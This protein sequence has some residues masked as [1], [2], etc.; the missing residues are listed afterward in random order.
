MISRRDALAGL[1]AL[2]AANWALLARAQQPAR[3]A[4]IGSGTPAGSVEALTAFRESMK[5]NAL[6]EGKDYVLDLFWSG[7]DYTRFPTLVQ[8]AL[9]RKPSIILVATIASVRAAQLATKTIPILM[10]GTNDPVGSGLVASLARPGGNTTGLA[11]MGNDR[12]PKLAQFV[13]EFL[14]KA[15]Y[16]A[17]LVNPLNPSNGPIFES[18]R[19]A[20]TSLGMS[21]V[22][23]EANSPE[24]IDDAFKALSTKRP[25]A[26]V[27][28]FDFIFSDQRGRI[29]QLGLKNK[30]PIFAGS[31]ASADA[32]ALI[33]FGPPANEL[34][35]RAAMYVKRILAGAKPADLPI[36]QPTKVELVLN[37]KTASALGIRIPQALVERADRV[38]E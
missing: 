12:A 33:G 18:I 20:A 11:T 28:G 25:D 27:T 4:W 5:A 14:P 21:T 30:I 17:V 23:V 6:A 24:R 1:L 15:R 22:A 7:G 26:L 3:L 8:E 19:N 13:R 38:I 10:L 35:R 9:T 34:P 31:V 36:E 32:G 37:L 16:I 29:A 2:G